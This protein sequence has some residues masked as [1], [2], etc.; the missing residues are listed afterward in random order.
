MHALLLPDQVGVCSQPEDGRI[1]QRVLVEE[2][3]RCNDDE[4]REDEEV[5]L[6]E[7]S[8]VQTHFFG[9]AYEPAQSGKPLKTSWREDARSCM[10]WTE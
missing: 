6:E 10:L 7:H 5:R 1:R 4:K 3:E 8:T 9:R 2:L